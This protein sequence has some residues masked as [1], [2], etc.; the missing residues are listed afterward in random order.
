M[1]GM[2]HE[3]RSLPATSLDL[4]GSSYSAELVNALQNPA[5][6]YLAKL[7]KGSSRTGTARLLNRIARFFGG[8][9]GELDWGALRHAHLAALR[10]YVAD[11]YASS[12]A[13]RWLT[14]A[15]GVLRAAWRMGRLTSE[16]IER[17][18][19][20]DKVRGSRLPR[21]RAVPAGELAALLTATRADRFRRKGV[22]DAALVAL[23]YGGGLRRAELV[24]L[25]VDD[26]GCEDAPL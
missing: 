1:L 24:S 5:F 21:G 8:T 9:I 11:R 10:S 26:F 15:R 23:L 12:T 4:S 25:D 18:C 2:T 13:N 16:E 17:A 22:R 19:D 20:L 6:A 14:V 7:T 3:E